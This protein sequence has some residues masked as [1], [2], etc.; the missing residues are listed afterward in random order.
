MRRRSQKRLILARRA[1]TMSGEGI[2]KVMRILLFFALSAL[3]IM[4]YE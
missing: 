4:T 1:E 2:I 3:V